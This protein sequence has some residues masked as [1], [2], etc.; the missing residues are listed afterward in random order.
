MID[1]PQTRYVTVDD[2]E[3][4]YQVLGEGPIDLVYHH[5]ACQIDLQWDV[6]PEAAFN[7][8]L[9][10]FSRLILFDR[11]GMGASERA[12]SAGVP[13]WERWGEDLLAVLD[14]VGSKS[15]SVFAEA[16][17]GATAVL[18]AAA[19]PERVNAL[20][21]GN[22]QARFSWADDYPIGMSDAEVESILRL[23]DW[24]WGRPE[25]LAVVFPSLADDN[26]ILLSLARLCRA[27]AT[28]REASALYRHIYSELD[29][30]N[31]L[32]LVQ[33]PTLVLHNHYADSPRARYLADHIPGAR[34]VAVPGDGTLFFGSA[35]EP[36]ISEVAE[37]LT[38]EQ[39]PTEVDRI[40][41][42]VLFTDIVASTERAASMGDRRWRSL[43]DAHDQSVRD[44]LRRFRGKE[45]KTTGDG[46]LASFDG[47]ARAIRCAQ[48]T[49]VAT[50]QLGLELRLGLHTG[51]CE[52][53]GE[54]LGG[55]AVHIAARVGAL[56][57]PGDVLV[58]GTVKDLVV[59][60]GI[61]FVDRGEHQLKGVPGDWKLFAVDTASNRGGGAA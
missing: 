11:R 10:S 60:S 26:Q 28:P 27:A 32:P 43:L 55:L 49:L 34:L 22:T 48:A 35:T 20:V 50:R 15:A 45:I 18:F 4:A 44:Q 9:A 5:G 61:P 3:V 33:A 13:E 54:D 40:L 2:A 17:A 57:G 59:G 1:Q 53:R 14:A 30:R 56:A 36:V 24:G 37:F 52:L 38:G 29:V 7:R 31:V 12:G 51:E 21:L 58:S 25:G 47:P 42:T 41:T 46:F 39:L 23:V 8:Q 16:E 19:H 6:V